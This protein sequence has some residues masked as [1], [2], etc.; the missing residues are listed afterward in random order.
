MRELLEIVFSIVVPTAFMVGFALVLARRE[1]RELRGETQ[2]STPKRSRL[3]TI[4]AADPDAHLGRVG[5]E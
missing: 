4:I 1:D 2:G 3:T 5:T